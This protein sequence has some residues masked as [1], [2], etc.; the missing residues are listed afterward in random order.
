MAV[1]ALNCP[2][3]EVHVVDI[4]EN[5]L[6]ELVRDIRSTLGYSTDDFKTFATTFGE[7]FGEISVLPSLC[8]CVCCSGWYCSVWGMIP[9]LQQSFGGVDLQ[10]S[11]FRSRNDTAGGRCGGLPPP[12]SSH[13]AGSDLS[14]KKR[15]Q[16][17]EG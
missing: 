4:S 14:K 17:K 9:C 11:S 3:L 2:E 10:L 8:L 6:A 12:G 7:V 15:D 5:N 13:P 1:I 16:R